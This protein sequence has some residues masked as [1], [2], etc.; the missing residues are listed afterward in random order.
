MQPVIDLAQTLTI[1]VGESR[2]SSNW[3]PKH[4]T[5]SQL[6]KRMR[7]VLRTSE[8]LAM[9]A[10]MSKDERAQI[11]DVGG[12]VGGLVEGGNRRAGS[13]YD[14]QLICLD[15]DFASPDLWDTWEMMVGKAA[16]MHS[17]HSS[18]REQP[19]LRLLVPLSRPVTAAEYEPIARRLAE[20]MDME[21]FD[22][23]TYE[24][25]RLMYW[26]SCSTDATY[27]FECNEDGDWV[28]PDEVLATYNDW[29][30]MREWPR[31]SRQQTIIRKMGE[32]QGDPLTKP[33]I[34]GAFNRAYSITEAIVKFLPGVYTPCGAGR[35]TYAAGSTTGGAVV[36]D[37]D[38]LLYS[39]HDTD[40]T[41]GRL[42]NAFDLVRLHLYGEQDA[43]A[44]PDTD[45]NDLPSTKAMKALCAGDEAVR[46]ELAE[47]I[48]RSPEE[49]FT[50]DDGLQR[51]TDDLTEQGSAVEFVDQYGAAL[52]YT[53]AF[54]WLFWDGVKWETDAEPEAHMLA[55]QFADT[56]YGQARVELQAA[57]DK[58]SKAQAEAALKR[59]VR[60]RTSAGQKGLMNQVQVILNDPKPE[61]YDAG[62]WDLNTPDGIIDL[63]TGALRPHDPGAKCTKIT[64]VSV[65]DAGAQK[66]SEFIRH[67]TGG[68][69]NFAR[70]LQTLAGMAAVGEVYEEGLVISYGPGGN[71]KSTFFGA[72][73]QV[74]GDYARGI[75]PDVL[76][77]SQGRVDQSYVA[78]LRGCRLAVM[79][80]T[81]EGARFG[82]AQMKRLTSRDVISARQ[83]YKDPIDFAPTHTVIMHTN[84]L[85]RLNSLD[86]GTKRRIA[87]APFPATLP[88]EQVVTNYESVLVRDCGGAILRWIVEGAALFY[89]AGCKLVKPAC[90]VEATNNYIEEEDWLQQFIDECCDVG[91]GYTVAS[92]ELYQVYT[93]KMKA[94]NGY[95]RASRD[96]AYSMEMKGYRKQRRADVRVWYGLRLKED[97]ASV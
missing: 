8:T 22:D 83:L 78:A 42:C 9:Y 4:I 17:T 46:G 21:Q 94:E 61:E 51:F 57:K 90:V 47:A 63:H 14:R 89:S 87:V 54:G 7:R 88:P 19:R 34:V 5:W 52:R 37:N 75:N 72:L 20:W 28:D 12:F 27:I 85:P 11:K 24:P 60:L 38:T 81:E 56:L 69:V 15:A 30:D 48:R 25:S 65:S 43:G 59:A 29:R 35:W 26:P 41:S 74:L 39:H 53:G 3:E 31:S 2:F 58:T 95:T 73:R 49:A 50:P 62:A 13:V 45:L 82:V 44:S 79:G 66:W 6:C 84:H 71:G 97:G 77:A 33:G 23:T 68:D 10:A 86:G 64:A 55:L 32:V 93:G 80:E 96:F 70:Y 76:V 91:D 67:I 92:G 1:S 18:T 16:L 40:P 36:Y